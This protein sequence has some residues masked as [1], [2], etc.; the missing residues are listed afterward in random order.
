M[1]DEV[2]QRRT[3]PH[4]PHICHMRAAGGLTRARFGRGVEQCSGGFRAALG[5]GRALVGRAVRR[6]AC[7]SILVSL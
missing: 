4:L 1:N 3:D 7:L 2:R 5:C 6:S